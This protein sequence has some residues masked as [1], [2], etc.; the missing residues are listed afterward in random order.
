M[1]E[2]AVGAVTIALAML[3]LSGIIGALEPVGPWAEQ[4]RGQK[5]HLAS[6]EPVD[7][8][9]V[10]GMTFL[11]TIV[12]GVCSKGIGTGVLN[13]MRLRRKPEPLEQRNLRLL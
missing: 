3:V 2:F 6:I 8:R 7:I 9:A 12:L 11:I 1:K 10:I 4:L 5:S 13:E